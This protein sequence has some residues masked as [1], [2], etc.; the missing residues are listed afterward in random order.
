MRIKV[1]EIDPGI[2]FLAYQK[3]NVITIKKDDCTFEISSSGD[4][5]HTLVRVVEIAKK[6]VQINKKG[7]ISVYSGKKG[8]PFILS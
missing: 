5:R 8:R 2:V 1:F 3:E 4:D 6:C 7:K